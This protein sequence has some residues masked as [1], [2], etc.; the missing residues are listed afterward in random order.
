[1]GY[2]GSMHADAWFRFESAGFWLLERDSRIIA[3]PDGWPDFFLD[4][5]AA[6][7]AAMIHAAAVVPAR[8]LHG[9]DLTGPEIPR[10][11][12]LIPFTGTPPTN[13]LRSGSS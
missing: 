1:M 11:R 12:A 5:T 8:E 2:D 7:E 4:R 6:T 10:C 13:P 3:R 9:S